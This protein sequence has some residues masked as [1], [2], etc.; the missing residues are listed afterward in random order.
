MGITIETRT[1]AF[2]EVMESFR[3]GKR[4]SGTAIRRPLRGIE[5]KDDTYAIMKVIRADGR[6]IALVDSGAPSGVQSGTSTEA[7]SGIP[8]RGKYA[9]ANHTFNYSNFIINQISESRSEKILVQETFGAPYAFF[10]GEKPRFLQ[11]RGLL[12]NTLDF[13]WRSEFWVNYENTLRGTKLVEQNARVYLHYDDIV[14][15]G[16]IVDAEA[17]DVAEMPYHIPFS[18]SMF[19][20]NHTYLSK[21]GDPL[22]P[23]RGA[24]QQP[25]NP[26]ATEV[27]NTLKQPSAK[28]LEKAAAA[29]NYKA[30]RLS[31]SVQAAASQAASGNFGAALGIASGGGSNQFIEAALGGRHLIEA[32]NASFVE[33]VGTFF[34]H[35]KVIGPNGAVVPAPPPVNLTR[36]KHPAHP[37]ISHNKDEY[38]GT[39]ALEA[40]KENDEVLAGL[41][42]TQKTKTP[43]TLKDRMISV[44]GGMGIQAIQHG[45]K[46]LQSKL[47]DAVEDRVTVPEYLLT[48]Y[49]AAHSI[50][51]KAGKLTG[52]VAESARKA[53]FEQS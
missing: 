11:V 46:K 27:N 22:Y 1:D 34:N 10:F 36:I 18:F 43:R 19:V 44:L 17:Q 25:T 2:Q 51:V 41:Q 23:K 9:K 20:T 42:Q 8:P 26:L 50:T 21:I 53:G 47:S 16:Y 33:A 52:K 35:K 38:L 30:R 12:F 32:G 31:Y 45:G 3:E 29:E 28:E 24:A 48:P 37:R 15:E 14:V 39:A 7:A 5:I 6:E 13:N 49:D 4:K 40:T